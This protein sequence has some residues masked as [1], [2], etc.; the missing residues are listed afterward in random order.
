[1]LAGGDSI[2]DTA[3]LRA[4]ATSKLFDATRAPSTIGSRLRGFK[5]FNVRQLDAVSREL[6]ARLWSARAGP[7]DMSAPLTIDLDST[8]VPVFGRGKQGAAFGYTK[9]GGY[10]PA[11]GHRPLA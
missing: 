4:G 11:A 1:M 8:I 5:W 9:V 7:A 10:Q 6:L 2:D 3:L